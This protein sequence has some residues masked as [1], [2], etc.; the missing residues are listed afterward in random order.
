MWVVRICT[1]ASCAVV[2]RVC[3]LHAPTGLA[4]GD[5]GA[6][7]VCTGE[8]ISRCNSAGAATTECTPVVRVRGAGC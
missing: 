3:E 7:V 6:S 8:D 1:R 4:H 2:L 5:A